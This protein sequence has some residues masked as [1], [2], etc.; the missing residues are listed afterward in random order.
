[1]VGGCPGWATPSRDTD[2]LLMKP[3]DLVKDLTDVRSIPCRRSVTRN[4]RLGVKQLD[5]LPKSCVL[6]GEVYQHDYSTLLLT[7]HKCATDHI[8][9]TSC[10][11]SNILLKKILQIKLSDDTRSV[12]SSM[13]LMSSFMLS[14]FRNGSTFD[15]ISS[16]LSVLFIRS[17]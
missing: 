8:K 7:F 17:I 11:E 14:V 4:K 12:T 3:R 10:V 5:S 9:F 6:D 13:T 1:M 2:L 16:H 15:V